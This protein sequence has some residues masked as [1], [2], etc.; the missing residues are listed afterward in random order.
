MGNA[1][2]YEQGGAH[3]LSPNLL[4]KNARGEVVRIN[5]LFIFSGTAKNLYEVVKPEDLETILPE[6]QKMSLDRSVIQRW[7][8]EEKLREVQEHTLQSKHW[9]AGGMLKECCLCLILP[10]CPCILCAD[11]TPGK[12]RAMFERVKK[13]DDALR[14]WQADF[15]REVFEP[16]GLFL[17][18]QSSCRTF[19]DTVQKERWFSI[20]LNEDEV[21]KLKGEDHVLGLSEKVGCCV[22]SGLHET[23]FCCH[24]PLYYYS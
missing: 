8:S 4:Q 12:Q 19:G 3:A 24:P 9:G 17:K 1:Q 23:D 11:R 2:S 5:I 10:F 6:L 20:A 15:N 7:F 18:T 22:S 14:K 16:R 21:H 13:W